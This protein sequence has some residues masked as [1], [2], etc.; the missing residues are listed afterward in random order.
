M[1]R[2]R[3]DQLPAAFIGHIRHGVRIDPPSLRGE[4]GFYG[5]GDPNCCPSQRL[6]V[7][8]ELRGDSLVL[9]RQ[10]GGRGALSLN[11]RRAPA[12]LKIGGRYPSLHRAYS[13][14]R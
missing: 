3:L 6:V 8:L 10:N 7:D 9:R 13:A 12:F 4:A 2:S 5:D 11:W 14:I 1:S